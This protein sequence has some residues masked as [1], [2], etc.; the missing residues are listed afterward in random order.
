VHYLYNVLLLVSVSIGVVFVAIVILLE[1]D[2][3]SVTYTS[4]P[5]RCKLLLWV[6]LY[7]R[8]CVCPFEYLKSHIQT[9]QDFLCVLFVAVARSLLWVCPYVCLCVCPFEYVK[10]H[11][12]TSQDFLCVLLVAVARS[13]SDDI[14]VP[15]VLPVL[16]MKLCFYTMSYTQ[17]IVLVDL[18]YTVTANC[19]SGAKSD[20]YNTTLVL[21][22]I[23]ACWLLMF[24]ANILECLSTTMNT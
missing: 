6:C 14:A 13:F 10:S 20:S 8:L 7:V 22:I 15:H 24:I 19:A 1:T 3:E 23:D 9:S 5:E 21:L 12:Q 11:I 18:A 4:P 2:C 17:R 16:W